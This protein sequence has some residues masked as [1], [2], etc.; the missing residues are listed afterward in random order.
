M[1]TWAQLKASWSEGWQAL[2]ATG[3]Q[4]Y[5]A[6]TDPE[7]VKQTVRGF[8]ADLEDVR[9]RLARM[10]QKAP[11]ATWTRR[12][13]SLSTR[14]HDLAAGLYA[15]ATPIT[16]PEVG[17]APV[18]IVGGLAVGA[19]GVAWAMAAHEYAANLRDQ[20][21]LAERE[22]EARI[23]ASREGR[24]LQPSTL[25]T[26]PPKPGGA[27]LLLLGGLALAAGATLLLKRT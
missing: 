6:A 19:V 25:P 16:R 23:A 13:A 20:T 9:D 3:R 7:A 10:R 5:A 21:A 27:G 18:L 11:D 8:V 1:S 14:Y 2:E 12:I 26:P 15:H 17:V 22:L 24:P 4:L